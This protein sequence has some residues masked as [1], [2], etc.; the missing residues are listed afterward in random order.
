[1]PMPTCLIFAPM[2]RSIGKA[3]SLVRT[4][5]SRERTPPNSGLQQTPPSPTLGR[6]S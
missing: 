6:R 2:Y 1:M 5:P 3:V 4:V